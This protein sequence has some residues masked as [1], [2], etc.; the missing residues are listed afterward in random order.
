MGPLNEL[1]PELVV[2]WVLWIAGGLLLMMWFWRRSGTARTRDAAPPLAH[3]GV[4]R[5]SGTHTVAGRS[6]SGTH[7][8]ARS[9]SGSRAVAPKSPSASSVQPPDAFAEL[10]A[11]LDQP[12]D[13]PRAG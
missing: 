7:A 2:G 1:P 13:P 10:R 3:G 8:A 9:L 4:A 5:L 12:D 6:A 11:L